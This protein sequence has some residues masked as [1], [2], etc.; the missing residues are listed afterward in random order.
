VQLIRPL[1]QP[2]A[3]KLNRKNSLGVG[4]L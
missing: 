3:R 2:A 4:E 1:R